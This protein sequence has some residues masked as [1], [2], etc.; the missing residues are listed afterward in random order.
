LQL[1]NINSIE[2]LASVVFGIS[3]HIEIIWQT[4]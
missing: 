4:K 2:V 1:S 3:A